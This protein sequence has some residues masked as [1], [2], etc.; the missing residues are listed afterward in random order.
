MHVS[1]HTTRRVGT[2]VDGHLWVDDTRMPPSERERRAVPSNKKAGAPVTC[3]AVLD[4]AGV[5]AM[6]AFYNDVLLPHIAQL[7]SSSSS[8]SS[9]SSASASPSPSSAAESGETT[10][11]QMTVEEW[12]EA[13]PEVGR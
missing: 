13:L 3:H 11:A 6:D 10:G 5:A 9:S 12:F 1:F 2:L 7:A 4:G 8:S